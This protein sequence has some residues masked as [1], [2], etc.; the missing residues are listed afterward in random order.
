MSPS[1]TEWHPDAGPSNG[2]RRRSVSPS[3]RAH[4]S[5]TKS[6]A[7]L[8]A[9]L[10]PKPEWSAPAS[11]KP[12]EPAPLRRDPPAP[13][14][15][16]SGGRSPRRFH[17]HPQDR[18]AQNPHQ[19]PGE[20]PH[21]DRPHGDRP[22]GDR[23]HPGD[24]R[25][26]WDGRREPPREP[27]R[28]R[29]HADEWRAP[30]DWDRERQ[31]GGG[32][33][34]PPR[35]GGRFSPRRED[36]RRHGGYGGPRGF[37]P[38]GERERYDERDRYDERPRYDSRDRR[39]EP[40]YDDRRYDRRPGYDGG[41]GGGGGGGGGYRD[42]PQRGRRRTPTPP[43]LAQRLSSPKKTG[44]E[45]EEGEIGDEEPAPAPPKESKRPPTPPPADE[46]PPPPPA[47]PPPPPPPP[48]DSPPPP[49]APPAEDAEPAP[50]PKPKPLD[51]K[52]PAY[53]PRPSAPN[54]NLIEPTTR[55]ST[56]VVKEGETPARPEP[57]MFRFPTAA[58]E[59]AAYSRE[60]V[61]TTTLAAYDVG[62]KLGE[63]TFGVVTKAIELATKRPVALKKLITHNLRDGVSV[64]TVREI[65]ILK[66]LNHKNVVPILDM[67]VE[68]K[69]AKDRSYR[70]EVF[71]VF[72]FMEHDLCGLLLNKDFK[73]LHSTQKLI[74]RQILDG[75]FYMHSNN[76]IHR[77]LKTA[78]ILVGKDGHA[79]IADFGL[80]RTLGVEPLP[81]HGEY[82]YTNLVVTRW[83]R[84]PE[85]L[86]GMKNYGTAIDMWSMGCI[87]GEMYNR[88]PIFPGE[89]DQDQCFKIFSRV[90]PPSEINW[91][92]WRDLPG[93]N[94]NGHEHDEPWEKTHRDHKS[95]L[96]HAK[97]WGM[98]RAGADLLIKL[99][100]LNPAKRLTASE[101]LDHV[102]FWTGPQVARVGN[103]PALE[104]S[105]E[106]TTRQRDGIPEAPPQASKPPA[107]SN[108]PRPQQL[109]PAYQQNRGPP[110]PSVFGG[111]R[112]PGG[113]H[114][115]PPHGG[116]PPGGRPP[117][118]GGPGGPGG[119]P[120]R[121]PGPGPGGFQSRPPMGSGGPGGNR[122][123]GGGLP[124]PPFKLAGGGGP[125]GGPGRGLPPPPG[126]L[127]LAGGV[128]P[129]SGPTF[130]GGGGPQGVKR[131][132][133]EQWRQD[134]R[135][136]RDEG[137]PY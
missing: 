109:Q 5:P 68:R 99:L 36:D 55:V 10:P 95:L 49:P 60:F 79:M 40:R 22:H 51:A 137:L 98:D 86:L 67:V 107:W 88:H 75:L 124:P 34:S 30:S 103:F 84:A 115:G 62:T 131:P 61:G 19:H 110:P 29:Y 122:G 104:S 42:E 11:T 59:T 7:P 117:Y 125:P 38:Y 15:N 74:F 87:L 90:G 134:K 71:M 25:P 24:R 1:R 135:P 26:E 120:F 43:P 119:P 48:A 85:L 27:P 39:P 20:R 91:P 76:I 6:L 132:G 21:G 97:D 102:W 17:S 93:F 45:P 23:P 82:E 53:V 3:K 89:S 12:A 37:P 112:G 136:R 111:G 65:K 100:L 128:R 16:S 78:N 56:P 81:K 64:T 44:P 54:R 14:S 73:I 57:K 13:P 41:V 108:G 2:D 77:D 28:D 52:A 96:L 118:G 69:A 129:T 83:Y 72:P 133:D 18:A 116:P 70:S 4:S 130:G 31:G 32:Y 35:H 50:A 105:H 8:P 58:Q 80:A 121:P 126:G 114:G 63:G 94:G 66:E 113:S 9:G 47:S 123:P 46:P 127:R 92:G 33:R 106:M 101:A